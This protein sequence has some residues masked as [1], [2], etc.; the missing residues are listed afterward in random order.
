MTPRIH[1]F[2]LVAVVGLGITLLRGC[3]E[4]SL[5][6]SQS[7]PAGA[8]VP[9]ISADELESVVKQS[10]RP[11]VVEFGV[12][13]GCF[14]CNDMRPRFDQLAENYSEEARFIR[15]D[16]NAAGQLATKYGATVCPS[17]VVFSNGES[18]AC[19]TYPTSVDLV[20]SD[21]DRLAHPEFRFQDTVS[22]NE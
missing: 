16:F 9:V 19:R 14:R 1:P 12:P 15:V 2:L 11:V 21:L 5:P 13:M 4:S 17:Y 22:R 10:T 7:R 20:A 6:Q 3:G 8:S 18:V